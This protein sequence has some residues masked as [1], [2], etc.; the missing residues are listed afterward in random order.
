MDQWPKFK[1][2]NHKIIGQ[3]YRDFGFGNGFVSDMTM[4]AWST[5]EKLDKLDH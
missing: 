3:K 4:K 2:S 1:N 5:K